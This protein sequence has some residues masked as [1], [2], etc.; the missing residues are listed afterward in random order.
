M[1]EEEFQ[2][3][4]EWIKTEI[5]KLKRENARL[6]QK[7]LVISNTTKRIAKESDPTLNRN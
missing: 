2:K 7:A 3:T 4:S 6:R 1:D 5:L